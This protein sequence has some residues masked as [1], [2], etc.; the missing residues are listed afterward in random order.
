MQNFLKVIVILAIIG[1]VTI[2]LLFVLDI[3][4]LSESREV[5]QKVLLILGIIAL[6]GLAVGLI[7]SRSKK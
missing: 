2:A 4:T 6:G 1:I 3:A 5:L 7:S